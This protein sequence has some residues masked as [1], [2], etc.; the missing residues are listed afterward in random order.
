MLR[1]GMP[2]AAPAMTVDDVAATALFLAADAPTAM[3]G[4]CLDLFG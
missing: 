2:G 1:H 4:A 3:T